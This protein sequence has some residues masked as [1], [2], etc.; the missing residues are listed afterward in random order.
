MPE[1]EW[2]YVSFKPGM[3][4][5]TPTING[6][7]LS[8]DVLCWSVWHGYS[9]DRVAEDYDCTREDVLVAC[10]FAGRY[11]EPSASLAEA[12]RWRKRWGTW[13]DE[14]GGLMWCHR[15]DEVTD[16]PSVAA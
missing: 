1:R 5:G 10:W 16:P 4:S 12:G 2:P 15:Y 14:M 7:R 6:T 13:A 11:G 8:I 3:Q 9:V